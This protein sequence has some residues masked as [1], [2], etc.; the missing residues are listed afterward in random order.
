MSEIVGREL[1]NL[2]E[3]ERVVAV[4]AAMTQGVGLKDFA[5]KYPERF[6]DVGIAESHA[7]TFCAGLAAGGFKPFFAVYSTLC[8]EP[9][10][11]YCMTWQCRSSM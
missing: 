9:T 5:E 6:F 11:K 2:G 1:L 7:V 3:D 4:S 10:T 8:R